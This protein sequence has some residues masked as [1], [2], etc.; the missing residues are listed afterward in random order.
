MRDEWGRVNN[1]AQAIRGLDKLRLE[2]MSSSFIGRSV[3]ILCNM[4][5]I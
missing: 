3:S 1:K 4:F 5:P 2:R